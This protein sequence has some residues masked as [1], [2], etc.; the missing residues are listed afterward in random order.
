MNAEA[1][2]DTN[3]LLY[4]YDSS[5]PERACTSVTSMPILIA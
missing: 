2:L 5:S 3:I 4:P 1:F